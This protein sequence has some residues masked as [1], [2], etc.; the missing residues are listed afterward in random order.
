MNELGM[1]LRSVTMDA[2]EIHGQIS[3]HDQT[4]YLTPAGARGERI[5]RGAFAKSIRER[6]RRI[7]LCRNHD[8]SYA[9]GMSKS[10]TDTAT[11][12]SAIFGVR[13]GARGD[14]LLE[15]AR[16]G[17]LP[18]LS[19]GFEPLVIREGRDG[20]IEVREAKLMEVSL[21]LIGAYDGA[22]VLAVRE[23]TSSVEDMLAP[24][25]NPPRVDLTPAN[26]WW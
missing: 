21:L 17:Y 5:K 18:A 9:F 25:R 23:A 19:V 8:H 26:R 20:A 11:D 1:E 4:S 16:D 3:V 2:R 7:P 10:W 24:F 6:G 13:S 15:E 14:E 22:R 12:L